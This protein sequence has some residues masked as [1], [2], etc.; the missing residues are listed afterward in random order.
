MTRAF[1]S[2]LLLG[3]A[4]LFAVAAP[5][6]AQ[7]TASGAAQPAQA[8]P[9]AP[10]DSTVPDVIVT[11]S[12]RGDESIRNVPITVQA[13]TGDTLAKA[14]VTQFAEYATRVPGLAFQDLGPGDKKYVIRGV[15]S[16][17][18]A[19][20]GAYYD[21]AVISADNRND[22][23][24]RN[25]DLKLYDIQR[26]EVL[27]GPQGTLYG[28]SSESGT[29]RIITNKPD[30]HNVSGYIAGDISGTQKGGANYNINGAI[31]LPIVDDKLALRVVGW[32]V[33]DSG[34]I[35]QPRI[36]SGR[37]DNVNNDR[38]GGG[39][40]LLRF[41]PTG[42]FS[43]TASATYQKQ[44]SDGSSRYT[45]P[46]TQSFSTT[47]FPAIPGG[48]LINTDLTRSPYDDTTQIYSLTGEYNFS[49]GSITATTNY[50]D[51]DIRFVFD[52]SPILFFFG[53][54]IPGITIQPQ[55]RRIWSNEIRYASKFS[56][57]LNVVVGAFYSRELSNFDVQVVR[58]N[59]L[60]EPRG[61][62]SRLNSDDALLNADGNTF[63]GRFDNNRLN[64][65][66]FFGELTYQLTHTL[67]ATGGVR[68]FRSSL[69]ATQET[70]H[71]FGGFG[72]NPVGVLTN[73]DSD[74]KVTWKG[75]LSW[76]PSHGV[77]VYATAASGFR[78]GGLNQADLPFASGI[79][80]GYRSDSLVNYELGTKLTL[81]GGKLTIDADVYHI[82]WS[83]IQ[84]R[85]VDATGAFPFTTNAGGAAV[86]GVEADVTGVLAKGVTLNFTASYQR[87]FLTSDQPGDTAAN[88]SLGR[89][90]DDI[91]N[92]PRFQGSLNLDVD[93]PLSG[94]F[95]YLI[96]ADVNYRGSSHTTLGRS[97]DGFDVA[98]SDYSL[99]NIRAGVEN[100]PWRVEL[101]VRNLFDARPQIDAISSSQD[102]LAY[103][104]VR[105]R[106]LGISATRKF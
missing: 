87:S 50:F 61:A 93:R 16:T 63:F 78:V 32:F 27:K 9:Q 28:A 70:T 42:N 100:G 26:I 51:R 38:T 97:R 17:G 72:P 13:L 47:G 56:G 19:T 29:I 71:P 21:E 44:H 41:T 22:G 73:D 64:Q 53:V 68:Y 18:A 99:T 94:H 85:A 15:N 92:V 65:Y 75:N 60:G 4:A 1:R 81:A 98:L 23:G 102:P 106:T 40:A 24:G 52:S 69:N 25:V 49:A 96:H 74:S 39:R 82:D 54:P 36:E 5:A 59:N 90:G 89:K 76:K 14:G 48:D 105:P 77:L 62:F 58:S 67:S 3:T 8:A 80:R 57:P 46:G 7:T 83:N 37:L 30:T 2:S 20:V 31:N 10:D 45:P 6:H 95:N 88:P 34:Y 91:P 11:A 84:V 43:I 35:D 86:N 79:P 12:K 33:S 55:S 104:T 66:A 101:Y 103:I